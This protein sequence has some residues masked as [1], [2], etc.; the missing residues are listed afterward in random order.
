MSYALKFAQKDEHRSKGRNN[1]LFGEP[2]N[3]EGYWCASKASSGAP[4]TVTFLKDAG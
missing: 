2:E 1:S 4:Q 3:F